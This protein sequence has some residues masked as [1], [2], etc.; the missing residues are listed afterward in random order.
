MPRILR[1]VVV[2]ALVGLVAACGT[3]DPSNTVDGVYDPYEEANRKRHAFNTRVDA[4]IV[5]PVSRRFASDGTGDPTAGLM[6]RNFAGNLSAPQAVVNHTLQGDLGNAT[7]MTTRFVI[8]T[9]LGFGG[10]ADVAGDIGLTEVDTDFGETLH[11][12]GVGEG[13]YVVVPF[14][15]PSNQRDVAGRVGDLFLDPLSYVL[16]PNQR[17][18]ATAAKV[19]G[20]LVSRGQFGGTVDSILHESADG[21]AQTRLI[22][23]LNRRDELGDVREDSFVDPYED[24]YA[25]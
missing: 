12:W 10:L 20:R 23:T 22:Y 15:G 14:I 6:L 25:D 4:N 7:R 21:Y 17:R 18:V 19:G 8:N 11:T 24:L 9:V 13:A 5:R 2:F 16:A 1:F 3:P